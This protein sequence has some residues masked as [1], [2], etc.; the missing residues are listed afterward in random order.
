MGRVVV[1]SYPHHVVQRGHS[2]QVV[3][4]EAADFAYYLQ[5]LAEFKAEYAVEVY[6]FCLMTNDVHLVLQPGERVAGLGQLMKR[7]AGR[8]TRYV[9]RQE[10]RSGTL[11]ESRY[12]SSPIQT[13][14]YLLACCR[15]VELNPVRARMVTRPEDYRWSSYGQRVGQRDEF[16]WLDTDPCFEGL[17]DTPQVR[18]SRYAEFV[19]SARPPG[20]WELIGSALQRGQLTGNER[21]IDEVAA[22]IG[23][24]IEHRQQGRPPVESRK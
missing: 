18:A 19:C 2:R 12:K 13:D 20:E 14:S 9:N 24:R 16:A 10:R 3:F 17:G 23:R 8:Q 5:T 6:G 22:I 1:P 21:F 15:Y 4:A 11:W 7:P